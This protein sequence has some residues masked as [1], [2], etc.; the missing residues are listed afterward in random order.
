M[1]VN[2]PLVISFVLQILE[3]EKTI[4]IELLIFLKDNLALQPKN[5]IY[6]IHSKNILK[7]FSWV[8]I[9]KYLRGN[10]QSITQISSIKSIAYNSYHK[11]YLILV[12]VLPKRAPQ[13]LSGLCSRIEAFAVYQHMETALYTVSFS[14]ISVHFI[15]L[16]NLFGDILFQLDPQRVLYAFHSKWR[17]TNAS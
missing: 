13:T 16:N 14:W 3:K 15:F 2:H 9:F 5:Y 6:I 12:F 7:A 11:H 10:L 8:K 1:L 17:G 4:L